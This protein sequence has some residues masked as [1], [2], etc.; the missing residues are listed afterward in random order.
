MTTSTTQQK[1]HFTYLSPNNSS[2]VPLK[3][4]RDILMTIY[5]LL[6]ENFEPRR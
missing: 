5:D 2:P 4:Q 1:I 3:K 6:N